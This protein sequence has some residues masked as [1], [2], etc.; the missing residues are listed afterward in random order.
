MKVSWD[1]RYISDANN[2]R[3]QQQQDASNSWDANYSRNN[4]NST[5]IAV[6]LPTALTTQKQECQQQRINQQ[7]LGQGMHATTHIKI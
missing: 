6:V 3:P 1:I 5:S 7:Q 2:C 4:R